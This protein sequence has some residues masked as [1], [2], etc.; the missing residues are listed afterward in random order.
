MKFFPKTRCWLFGHKFE[1]KYSFSTDGGPIKNGR[2]AFYECSRC[3]ELKADFELKMNFDKRDTSTTLSPSQ[4]RGISEA[5]VDE[6]AGFPRIECN[7]SIIT[8]DTLD[9]SI[10]KNKKS[11]KQTKKV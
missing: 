8:E 2:I 1:E 3:G 6:D 11:R 5:A 10:D 9:G 4:V 7:P